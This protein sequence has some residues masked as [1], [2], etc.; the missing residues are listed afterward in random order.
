MNWLGETSDLKRW[1]KDDCSER[2]EHVDSDPGTAYSVFTEDDSFGPVLRYIVCRPC[3]E[4]AKQEK[5]DEKH[6]CHDCGKS[7]RWAEGNTWKWYDFYAEQG[8]QPMFL[9]F[10]CYD[11]PKHQDR[12][13]RDREEERKEL[14]YHERVMSGGWYHGFNF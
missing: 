8:D 1:L 11:A 3:Y 13:A 10:A 6:V 2:C 12:M 4:K 9:C 7:V 5:N 14:D